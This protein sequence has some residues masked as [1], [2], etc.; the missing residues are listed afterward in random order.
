MS[1][2]QSTGGDNTTETYSNPLVHTYPEEAV[3]NVT[4]E[5]WGASLME[6]TD[7]VNVESVDLSDF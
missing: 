1:R 3:H 7:L 5:T 4:I 6:I 2:E